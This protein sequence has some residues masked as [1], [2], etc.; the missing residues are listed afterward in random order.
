MKDDAVAWEAITLAPWSK[1]QLIDGKSQRGG[2][3]IRK[4]VA[5]KWIYRPPTPKE[6]FKNMSREAW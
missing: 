4:R 6:E 2:L 1:V 5:G 3:V